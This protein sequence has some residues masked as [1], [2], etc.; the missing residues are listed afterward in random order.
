MLVCQPRCH[1][2]A[3]HAFILPSR[4]PVCTTM[5]PISHRLS[6]A[7]Y[8]FYQCPMDGL[9]KTVGSGDALVSWRCDALLIR[10]SGNYYP[11]V[12]SQ[13]GTDCN[14]ERWHC[15]CPHRLIAGLQARRRRDD[16]AG[17]LGGR[18][19][20]AHAQ[21]TERQ[22]FHNSFGRVASGFPAFECN[23]Y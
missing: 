5:S 14:Q 20:Y 17:R 18:R 12:C 9:W 4:R 2:T 8:V 6:S 10:L 1:R 13:T 11:V 15:H 16:R 23:R 22:V 21:N 7:D 3:A 19:Y